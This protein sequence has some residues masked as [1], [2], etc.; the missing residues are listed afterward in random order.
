[1]K[2]FIETY[3]CQM[4][5]SDSFEIRKILEDNCFEYTEDEKEADVIIINTC[6]VRETAEE[7]VFGRLGI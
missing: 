1:M 4:N 3:G 7:R 5:L 6:S 2:F